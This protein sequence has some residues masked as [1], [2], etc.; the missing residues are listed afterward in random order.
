VGT[1]LPSGLHQLIA[2][3]L[4]HAFT[5]LTNRVREHVDL[6]GRDKP[7]AGIMI[8]Q[9]DTVEIVDLLLQYDGFISGKGGIVKTGTPGV[10]PIKL[11]CARLGK[12]ERSAIGGRRRCRTMTAISLLP[13]RSGGESV[14]ESTPAGTT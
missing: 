3:G 2:L 7:L 9:Q 5:L 1:F 10:D 13:T 6:I 12:G 8:A 14:N 4:L 11:D